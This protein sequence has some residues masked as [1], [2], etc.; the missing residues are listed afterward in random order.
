MP[1]N[2]DFMTPPAPAEAPYDFLSSLSSGGA[3]TPTTAPA[4]TMSV[5]PLT[6]SLFVGMTGMGTINPQLVETPSQPSMSEFGD[7]DGDND[8]DE[9]EDEDDEDEDEGDGSSLQVIEEEDDD[10]RQATAAEDYSHY[11]PSQ[12]RQTR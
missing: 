4:S 6:M 2:N 12:S 10:Y 5:N 11:Q 1:L 9:D 8:M 3:P 7:G